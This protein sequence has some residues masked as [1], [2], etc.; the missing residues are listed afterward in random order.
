MTNQLRR[1]LLGVLLLSGCGEGTIEDFELEEPMGE[2]AIDDGT[3]EEMIAD[4]DPVSVRC[5]QEPCAEDDMVVD[6]AGDPEPELDAGSAEDAGLIDAGVPDAGARDAGTPDAG[7][8]RD[9]GTPDA[10]PNPW[11][12]GAKVL[13]RGYVSFRTAAK[14]DAGLVT[15]AQ[16]AGG[17]TDSAHGGGMTRGVVPPGQA[18]TLVTGT[19]TNG[20]YQVRYAGLTGWISGS[21]LTPIPTTSRAAFAVLPNVR[22]AFF[23]NQL[24]RTRWN[25]DGPYSSGTCAPTSLAMA[26]HAFGREPATLSVEE[27]IHRVRQSYGATS[28]STGTFRSQITNG[29]RA[30]GMSVRVLDTRLSAT[31]S[32]TRLD[33][34]LAAGR[35]VVLEGQSASGSAY[36]SAF[37]RAYIAEGLSNRYT[38][39]GRH[40]I[41]V[42]GRDGTGYVVGDPLSEVGMVKL[43]GAELKTFFATWGGTGNAVW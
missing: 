14:P 33:G 15:A 25:K 19:R 12:A 18:V 37:N 11:G 31:D 8:P 2:V 40:S 43:T 13:V 6:D 1:A 42:I 7:Q 27:S 32:L 36:H 5:P 39:A 29:A 10:G 16:P 35:M 23:K 3:G 30:L 22:N 28:D 41:V 4:P 17:V 21:W 24:H 26:I 34:Q 38:F 20:Y 9:A